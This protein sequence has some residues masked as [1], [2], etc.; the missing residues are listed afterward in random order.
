M[1]NIRKKEVQQARDVVHLVVPDT[2][3]D[4]QSDI[5]LVLINN[6]DCRNMVLAKCGAEGALITRRHAQCDVA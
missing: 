6:I 1:L 4:K 5:T 2:T 3:T